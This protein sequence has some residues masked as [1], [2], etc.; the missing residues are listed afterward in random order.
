[1]SKPAKNKHTIKKICIVGSESTGKTTLAIDLAKHYKTCWVPEYGRTY[2]EGR[3]YTKQEAWES[4]EFTF[5][6]EQQNAFEDA[7]EKIA[8]K[9]LICDTDA[10]ATG[11]W[12]EKYLGSE[13]EEVKRLYKDRKY[14]LYILTD[15][16]TPYAKDDIRIGE[17]SRL[18]MHERFVQELERMGRK[19]IVVKGSREER[20]RKVVEE[21]DL[22]R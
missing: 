1:M 4:W 14:D 10:F 19:Y 5:I 13:S 15:P 6:A 21:I 16:A 20:V 7:L 11:I 9:V 8:S 17:D 22:K 18:W 2:T 3:I 12:H